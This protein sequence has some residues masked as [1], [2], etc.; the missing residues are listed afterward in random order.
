[1]VLAVRVMKNRKSGSTTTCVNYSAMSSAEFNQ[2][3][4]TTSPVEDVDNIMLNPDTEFSVF[5]ID[6][7][8]N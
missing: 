6:P 1:M 7:I 8:S 2:A 5:M 4:N 3:I